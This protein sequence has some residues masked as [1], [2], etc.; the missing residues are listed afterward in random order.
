MVTHC[1]V[2]SVLACIEADVC[3]SGVILQHNYNEH[4]AILV[5]AFFPGTGAMRAVAALG[6]IAAAR[7]W[8]VPAP[9]APQRPTLSYA[10]EGGA[11]QSTFRGGVRPE[12]FRG[13]AAEWLPLLSPS[14]PLPRALPLARI[15]SRGC[16]C[17]SS[18]W[19]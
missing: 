17:A 2:R 15:H 10:L 9:V 12:L 3:K 4:I 18:A 8:A 13:P 16:S 11:P 19:T 14:S 7:L 5:Q 1:F 6:G